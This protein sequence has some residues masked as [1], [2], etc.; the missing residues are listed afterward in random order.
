[1][2][3]AD[4]NTVVIAGRLVRDVEV[5]Y[6]NGG[7]PIATFSIASNRKTKKDGLWTDEVG[8]FDVKL[9]GKQVEA[10][11]PYLVKAK[12]VVVSGSVVQERWEKEGKPMSKIVIVASSVQLFGN[13]KKAETSAPD[14]FDNDVF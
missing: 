5:K 9:W 2:S 14:N 13:E 6:T 12:K 11:R 7:I 1:M 3:V 10:L 8:F 4:I